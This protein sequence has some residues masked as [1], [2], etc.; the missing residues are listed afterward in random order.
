MPDITEPLFSAEEIA[1]L[2]LCLDEAMQWHLAWS[3]RL[4]RCALLGEQPSADMLQG[5]AHHLC[6]FGRWF[7]TVR[8]RLLQLEPEC[9]SALDA[10]HRSMHS[11]VRELYLAVQ[12]GGRAEPHWFETF[13]SSQAA[14]VR[15]LAYLKE[16]F[17]RSRAQSDPLTGLPLRHG[18]HTLFAMRQA[19]AGRSGNALFIALVDADHFKQINDSHGHPAGDAVLVHLAGLLKSALRGNDHLL[20]YGGE[21][22]MLLFLGVDDEAAAH[23]AERLLHLVRTSPMRL[24]DGQALPL[25]IS[26]GMVRVLPQDSLESAIRRADVALY[27]AKQNGRDRLECSPQ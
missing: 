15:E 16:R 14:M 10:A 22:F 8:E 19:D 5:D 7:D 25:T 2:P 4:L 17:V 20:R 26:I 21:E 18:L 24:P 12:S 3:Q 1:E 13:E 27:R 6:A 23:V 11:A 9:V